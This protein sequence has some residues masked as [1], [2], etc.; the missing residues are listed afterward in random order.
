M[1]MSRGSQ[2]IASRQ[3][4]THEVLL[5]GQFNNINNINSCVRVR[6]NVDEYSMFEEDNASLSQKML[7]L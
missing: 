4:P 3:R 2:T 1:S 7:M 5:V 6:V